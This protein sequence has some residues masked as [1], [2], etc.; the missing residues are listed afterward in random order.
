MKKILSLC[1]LAISITACEPDD[2]SPQ[3]EFGFISLSINLS[4]S[5]EESNGR[6]DGAVPLEEFKVVVKQED[7]IVFAEYNRYDQ[8]PAE[9]EL[10]VGTYKVIAFSDNDVAAAFEN[11]YYYGESSLF[12]VDKEETVAV[13]VTAELSNMKVTVTYSDNVVNGFDSY[14]TT[15]ENT[16]GDVLTFTET[17]TRAGY[18]AVDPLTI[19]ASLFYTKLD[20]EE[21]SIQYTGAITD[22]QPKTHYRI[23]ID[24]LLQNGTAAI[25]VTL[26]ESVNVVDLGLG[27]ANE[28]NDG[29]G[30][31][32]G[33]GDCDDSDIN[34]YPN[35]PELNDG[36]DNNC[37][38]SIDN[39]ICGNGVV[40]WQ[41]ECDGSANCLATCELDS[42][43]DGI[44][45]NK[46]NCPSAN[47]ATQEDSDGDGV[48]NICDNCVS[49]S[50]ENQA[51]SDNDGVGNSCDNCAS[52]ANPNQADMDND[53]IGDVCD[54]D[55]DGDGFTFPSD[56][57][58]MNPLINP[59]AP[60]STVNG[61]DEN[62]D[63]FDGI[64]P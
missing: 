50:N 13:S 16:T 28:D 46:D 26:D 17:E 4:V 49:V 56:C 34:T 45:D 57:D 3:E 8:V 62:C 19:V 29:D 60:D 35:A 10:P 52:I 42:D 30:V 31:T 9:I 33:Q 11:P 36:K 61:I 41:E 44:A 32:V 18:F 27:N 47:N 15:V 24:A 63:G 23:N 51:D 58:D 55:K 38:G 22:P 40:D 39:S 5:I 21:V 2:P 53:G 1:L 12:T 48:G 64:D 54:S 59:G 14:S 20:G 7:G 43:G 25:D 6:V 37:D